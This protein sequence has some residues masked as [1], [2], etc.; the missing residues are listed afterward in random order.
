MISQSH[1]A[2]ESFCSDSVSSHFMKDWFYFM[3]MWFYLILIS[4]HF[5]EAW[6]H[7]DSDLKSE[8]N[9]IFQFQLSNIDY[10][11][12]KEQKMLS[13][14]IINVCYYI[15]NYASQLAVT[16]TLWEEPFLLEGA[17]KHLTFDLATSFRVRMQLRERRQA[18]SVR[19]GRCRIQVSI[20]GGSQGWSVGSS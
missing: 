19:S 16:A 6:F 15:F 20:L 12:Q 14:S 9:E 11:M 18:E 17:S 10:M 1:F 13:S 2:R 3:K 8:W 5:T 7:S 4:S